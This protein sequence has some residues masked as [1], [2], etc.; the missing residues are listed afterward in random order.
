MASHGAEETERLKT[1]VQE[2]LN[3]EPGF[4]GQHLDFPEVPIL[5]TLMQAC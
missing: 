4:L 1:N 3:R 2:Q 5:P